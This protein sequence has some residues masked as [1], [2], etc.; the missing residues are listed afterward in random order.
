MGRAPAAGSPAH[1]PWP[2]APICREQQRALPRGKTAGCKGQQT[3]PHPIWEAGPSERPPQGPTRHPPDAATG[4]APGSRDPRREPESPPPTAAPR[5]G[6]PGVCTRA[7]PAA[8]ASLSRHS[9]GPDSTRSAPFH[10]C[11][12]AELHNC[13]PTA[14]STRPTARRWGKTAAAPS[15]RGHGWV[16]AAVSRSRPPRAPGRAG[17]R[18]RCQGHLCACRSP[19]SRL[20]P[21]ART[22]FHIGGSRSV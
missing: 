1:L 15:T 8:A 22:L 12:A 14:G 7:G 4:N 18:S 2:G 19:V 11:S 10:A 17:A 20:L 5:T 9:P 16:C 21:H 13:L 3:I 6:L